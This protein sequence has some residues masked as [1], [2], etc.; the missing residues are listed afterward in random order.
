MAQVGLAFNLKQP[1][2][3]GE[4]EEDEPPDSQAEY[5]SPETM[6]AVAEALRQ[7]GHEVVFLEANESFLERLRQECP[8]VVFNLAEGLRGESRESHV[9]AL[10]EMLGIP[11]TGSGVL[12]LAVCLDK[13][14][15][16]MLLR[17]QGVRTPGFRVVK[18]GEEVDTSGLSFPLFVKPAHEG[19]SMGVTPRSVVENE[20]ELVRQ[21]ACV[22][23]MYRQE[24]LVEEFLP[25]R[26]FTVGLLG[27]RHLH[28]FPIMEINYSPVPPEHGAVYSRHF[29]EHWDDDR[30]Y[31]CPAPVSPELERQLLAAATAAFRALGCRDVARVDLRLDGEGRVHVLELNP[32]PGMAPGFSDLPRAAAAGGWSYPEL[33]NGILDVC[34]YRL[35]MP[36]LASDLLIPRKMLA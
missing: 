1:G 11:Y 32:L 15:A 14:V 16:K 9:P 21:V 25:G 28:A 31:L 33:V 10:L 36:H 13:P 29:K 12:S 20:G 26:E 5:D 30:Y 18:P 22:H 23:Q 7:G 17:Q 24:A 4:S 19:S 3:Q 8:Q 2:W 35:G 34:L 6:Q 27:N